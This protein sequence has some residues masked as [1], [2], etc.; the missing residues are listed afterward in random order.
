M[1]ERDRYEVKVPDQ[2]RRHELDARDMVSEIVGYL[3]RSTHVRCLECPGAFGVPL[4]R[5]NIG[6]YSQRCH[7]CG[8]TLVSPATGWCELFDTK[9][10]KT[11]D[12]SALQAEID[13][14]D[15]TMF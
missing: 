11:C 3:V 13:H 2:T 4:Y 9:D 8:Q 7:E 15:A 14:I 1:S 10:C 6:S 5:T 12:L